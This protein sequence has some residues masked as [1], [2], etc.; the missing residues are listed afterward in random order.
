MRVVLV[1]GI[2]DLGS[3]V[4]HRLFRAGYAVVIHDRIRPAGTR[5]AMAFTDAVWDEFA[6]LDG[7]VAVR[8]DEPERLADLLA[9][10]VVIPVVVNSG[11]DA[12]REALG[13]AVIVDARLVRNPRASRLRG[14]APLTIGLGPG[15]VAGDTADLVVETRRG[16]SLGRLVT[17]T[18]RRTGPVAGRG[19]D[20]C[21]FAP[22]PGIFR[23]TRRI[24]DL[25]HEGDVVGR[26]AGAALRAPLGGKLRGLARDGVT[27]AAGSK[28]AEIDRR[29]V[30]A[31][32]A[33]IDARL[34]RVAEG[35]LCAV[36]EWA[37][38]LTAGAGAPA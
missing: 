11:F 18:E 15:F 3:A 31:M 26:I 25:V 9:L 37:T 17:T 38:R 20:R 34:A 4:A 33:G 2:G 24:G 35:V 13:A 27:V 23:A 14:L 28:V 6:E 36:Q 12:L 21:V 32:V 19:S 22:A 29:G 1:R 16:E 30:A 5:R 8:V 10:K 7:V